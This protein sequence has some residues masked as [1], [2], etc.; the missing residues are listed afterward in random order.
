MQIMFAMMGAFGGGGRYLVAALRELM[1][2]G[3]SLNLHQNTHTL[4][5]PNPTP[6]DYV[7][8][9]G[10]SAHLLTSSNQWGSKGI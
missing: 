2:Q 6:C 1:I 9:P 10:E 4:T 3:I 5:V 8:P 7:L